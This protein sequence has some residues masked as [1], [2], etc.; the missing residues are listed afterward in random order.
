MKKTLNKS[1]KPIL[2]SASLLSTKPRNIGNTTL[3]VAKG[4]KNYF[5]DLNSVII[6]CDNHSADG[7]RE[8]FFSAAGEIP[9]IYLSTP[10][11]V[12]GKGNSLRIF[13][14]KVRELKAG[15]VI[16][17]EADIRNISPEWIRNLGTPIARG[18]GYT[19]PLYV[20]HKYEATLTSSLIYPLLRCLYGRRIRQPNVGDFG[21]KGQLVD[22]FLNSPVWTDA[23]EGY[24]VDIWMTN[25]ALSSRMPICQS[26]MGC[27][28][29]HRVI[30]P[31]AHLQ[32]LFHQALS[33]IFDLMDGVCRFL[34]SGE[35]EQ[36]RCSFRDGYTRGGNAFA[37]RNQCRSDA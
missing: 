33:T 27:P 37:D 19:V 3:Q 36:T 1:Q 34:A 23:V 28:K 4:L 9:K 32:V 22:S 15:I 6:N 16:V 24:G 5:G 8:A 7:T 2:W 18:A 30:D 29:I 25:I 20:R 12:R 31:Y 35:M 11:G 10:P 21:F 17:V 26:F 13:F 14:E